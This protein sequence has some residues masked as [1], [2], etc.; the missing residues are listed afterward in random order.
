MRERK[1]TH[2]L[3]VS[4]QTAFFSPPGWDFFSKDPWFNPLPLRVPRAKDRG[5][6]HGNEAGGGNWKGLIEFPWDL[7]HGT[8]SILAST[9][10]SG[11]PW[12]ISQRIWW[13]SVG[14]LKSPCRFQKFPLNA[15]QHLLMPSVES[16]MEMDSYVIFICHFHMHILEVYNHFEI[17]IYIDR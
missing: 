17:Y 13:V 2:L 7:S 1:R 3:S 16:A 14:H 4:S 9:A 8:Q 15:W 5:W 11:I 12:P 10:T 6:R